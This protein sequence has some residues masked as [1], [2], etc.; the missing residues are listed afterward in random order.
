MMF[1]IQCIRKS[2]TNIN[3]DDKIKD[4]TDI[5]KQQVCIQPN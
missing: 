5:N 3:N 4:G 1:H 2:I